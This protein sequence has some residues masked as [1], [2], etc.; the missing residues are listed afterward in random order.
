MKKKT[1]ALLM[2]LVLIFG[3]AVGGTIAWLMDRTEAVVNTFTVGDIEIE[4]DETKG[5]P[6]EDGSHQFKVIPGA[7]I[8]KDP[9]VTVL[10]DSEACWLFVK[11]E[12]ANWIKDSVT[13]K[14]LL[15][16]EIAD[17]WTKLE[18]GVYYRSVP[19]TTENEQPFQILKDNKVY[20]STDMDAAEMET[21]EKAQPTLTFTAYAIQSE[22]VPDVAD[23]WAQAK[24][25]PLPTT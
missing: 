9:V 12:K 17:G 7:A 1:V 11:I 15:T 16:Y 10:K 5:T 23:A 19:A 6:Q 3:V 4:L 8:D 14:D 24:N 18:E 25:A 13:E 2:S 22:N 21:I 20:V